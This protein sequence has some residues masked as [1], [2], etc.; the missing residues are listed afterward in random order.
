MAG[1]WVRISMTS[2]DL[3]VFSRHARVTKWQSPKSDEARASNRLHLSKSALG[4]ESAEGKYYLATL[5]E[6]R[7]HAFLNTQFVQVAEKT[8]R[9]RI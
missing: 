2:H 5:M 1:A 3:S 8:C 6:I 7:I 9:D 4:L